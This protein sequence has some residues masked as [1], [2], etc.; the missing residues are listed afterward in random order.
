M[1]TP[2][3]ILCLLATISPTKG[4]NFVVN[5]SFECFDK[6]WYT[7]GANFE[8]AYGN[9]T[10]VYSHVVSTNGVGQHGTHAIYFAT[11]LMSWSFYLT[12]ATYSFTFSARGASAYSMRAD[13][14]RTAFTSLTPTPTY[15]VT[16]AWQRFTN[17]IT[18]GTNGWYCIKFHQ[19][20]SIVTTWIDAVQLEAGA[21][22][23]DFAPGPVIEFGLRANA[24]NVL[25]SDDTR[26]VQC[27]IWNR[28]AQTNMTIHYDIVSGAWNTNIA[29]G[30]IST[31]ALAVGGTTINLPLPDI[32]GDVRILGYV[33]NVDN[34]MEET[35]ATILP[36]TAQSGT[37]TNGILG[38]DTMWS[39]YHSGLVRRLGFTHVRLLSQTPDLRWV[40]CFPTLTTTNFNPPG[41]GVWNSDYAVA[42]FADS[43]LT[44]TVCLVGGN[45]GTWYPQTNASTAVM[46]G[47][48]T[49]YVGRVVHRYSQAPYNVHRWE[50]WNEPQQNPRAAIALYTPTVYANLLTNTVPLIRAIDLQGYII[51]GGGLSQESQWTNIW[52]ATT[53]DGRALLNAVSFHIYPHASGDNDPN[54]TE[55]Q[56]VD[57]TGNFGR[58]TAAVKFNT[59][60]IDVLNTETATRDIGGFHTK[61]VAY[62]YPYYWS[63]PDGWT[64]QGW[65]NELECRQVP[66]IDRATYNFL[67]SV[68]CGM[69]VWYPQYQRKMDETV[70]TGN[71]PNI[72]ELS[73]VLKPWAAAVVVANH[74]VRVPGQGRLNNVN[75]YYLEAYIHSN[76]VFGVVIPIWCFDR[77]NRT[78]TLTNKEFR[79]V[80]TMG[81]TISTNSFTAPITRS[82]RYIVSGTS[83]INA[84]SNA[85]KFATVATNVYTTPPGVTV[86]ITPI[87][88]C[89][90]GPGITNWF[91]AT[92]I[93]ATVM[94]Y[95]WDD[96]ITNASQTNV[97]YSWT[98]NEGHDWSPWGNTNHF[99]KSFASS[100]LYRVGWKAK[101]ILGTESA[102][103]YT[104]Y[105]GDL[106]Y[107]A[108]VPPAE[109]IS[110]RVSFSGR[111]KIG[112]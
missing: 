64:S 30:D 51:G 8:T 67:Q 106:N 86:D 100:G 53:T 40:T 37:D 32:L 63:D 23:T 59:G 78:M 75:Q 17:T 92:A 18:V 31:N 55:D 43:G 95:G 22:A 70:L 13:C 27:A 80:D 26:Q 110:G 73:G 108:P 52:N 34:T 21:N 105:F 72:T 45:D 49:N 76:L 11:R 101:N 58:I 56:S 102:V 107:V 85:V 82:A 10:S 61:S 94:S 29:S 39:P 88:A 83:E 20:A 12:N 4:E 84:L 74:L 15:S 50:V 91:K 57:S 97:M 19:P 71:S 77:G 66:A 42:S 48:F 33:T 6:G 16:T 46:I 93:D 1:K 36:F 60:N 14:V 99:Q 65:F 112:R 68:G 3:V 35:A 9:D 69:K 7:W 54:D 5:G 44:L 47:D 109:S 2:L 96:R 89:Q 103:A 79:L 25:F 62:V 81:N 98:F 24:D 38:I 41:S 87:G 111:L 28:V 104:P 90:I